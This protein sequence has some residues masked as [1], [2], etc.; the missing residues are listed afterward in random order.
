MDPIF[1]YIDY[2]LFLRDY[3]AFRKNR[4]SYFSYRWFA[5]HAGISSSGLYQR[6]VK[7]ERNLTVKSCEQFVA[8][9]ELGKKESDYFRL[10]VSFNQAKTAKEKQRHYTLMLSMA[11][12]IEEHQLAADEYDY[13]SHWYYPVLRELVTLVDFG[14]DFEV[15]AKSV[16][17]AITVKQARDGVVL[18]KRLGFIEKDANGLYIQRDTAIA[19]MGEEEKMLSLA[20]RSFHKKMLELARNTLDSKPV[21]KRFA[22]GIT[23]G[24]SESCYDVIQQEY[25]AFRERVVRIVER[26]KEPTKVCQ[27]SFQLFP[28]SKDIKRKEEDE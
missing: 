2:R 1:Q 10:L 5:K 6:V 21:S 24:I 23:M 25:E 12:F 19:S 4:D 18:L 27:M 3:F 11:D 26:D 28:L 9:M 17:P 20:R 14:S 22:T 13:V 16:E 15:L 7:G 8:G